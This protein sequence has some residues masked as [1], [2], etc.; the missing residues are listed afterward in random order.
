[1]S[2]KKARSVSDIVQDLHQPIEEAFEDLSDEE[3]IEAMEELSSFCDSCA[4]AK[5]EEMEDEE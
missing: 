1:M 2:K 3:Y 5:R 4:D